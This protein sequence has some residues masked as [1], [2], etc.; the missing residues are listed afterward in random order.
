MFESYKEGSKRVR[1]ALNLAM[2]FLGDV[3]VTRDGSLQGFLPF[4]VMKLASHDDRLLACCR[5]VRFRLHP[6]LP[7]M[8]KW[9]GAVN[10]WENTQ[11]GMAISCRLVNGQI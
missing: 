1:E 6:A 2:A 7:C 3:V 11:D 9:R 5:P 8:R 10:I 4:W